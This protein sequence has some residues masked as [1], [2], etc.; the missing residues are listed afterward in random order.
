MAEQSQ[1]RLCVAEQSQRR[2]CVT[3]HRLTFSDGAASDGGIGPGGGVGRPAARLVHA[4]HRLYLVLCVCEE[5]RARD[6]L[7]HRHRDTHSCPAAGRSMDAPEHT[8]TY[9]HT[10]T[11]DSRPRALSLSRLSQLSQQSAVSWSA[12]NV[13]QLM[14]NSQTVSQ[15]L[16]VDNQRPAVNQSVAGKLMV[17]S[18]EGLVGSVGRA[19][20]TTID[21]YRPRY[22]LWSRQHTICLRTTTG[23]WLRQS[24]RPLG[25]HPSINTQ[26]GES[27][28]Q[29][30]M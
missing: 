4:D 11:V 26:S 23:E 8:H 10:H 16:V 3:E 30:T 20:R 29:C 6:E 9:R 27:D 24:T 15:Y 5:R 2:R 13:S 12:V 17:S 22:I 19:G 28:N 7:T 14:V 18:Q 1:R 21:S 25:A